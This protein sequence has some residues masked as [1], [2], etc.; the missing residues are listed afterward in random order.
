MLPFPFIS[1]DTEFARQSCP[2]RRIDSS[3]FRCNLSSL[4]PLFFSFVDSHSHFLSL[5]LSFFSFFISPAGRFGNSLRSLVKFVDS[6]RDAG[7]DLSTPFVGTVSRRAYAGGSGLLL[8][9]HE[10]TPRNG[11]SAEDVRND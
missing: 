6:S 2:I 8:K 1:L 3:T 5:S 9:S 11:C 10:M 4:A 7:L